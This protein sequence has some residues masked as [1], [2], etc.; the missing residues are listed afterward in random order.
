MTLRLYTRT[1]VVESFGENRDK[2]S[3]YAPTPQMSGGEAAAYNP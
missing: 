1:G 2:E 3:K